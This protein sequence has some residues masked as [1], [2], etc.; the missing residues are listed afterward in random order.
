LCEIAVLE[1]CVNDHGQEG[2][3]MEALPGPS[4]E[5]IKPEI[6]VQPLICLF[7]NPSRFDRGG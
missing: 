2:M 4:F 3:S 1:E 5:V 6:L 7:A